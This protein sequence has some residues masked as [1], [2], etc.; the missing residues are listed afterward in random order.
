MDVCRGLGVILIVIVHAGSIYSAIGHEAV[1]GWIRMLDLAFAPYRVPLLMVLS[2]MLLSR[3]LAKGVSTYVKGKLRNLAWP[4]VIWTAIY[5]LAVSGPQGWLAIKPWLGNTPFWYLAYLGVFFSIG[6]VCARVPFGLIAVYALAIAMIAPS[7]PIYG[8][9]LFVMMSYFFAGAHIGLYLERTPGIIRS[10]WMVALLPLAVGLSVHLMTSEAAAKYSPFI[11]PLVLSAILCLCSV[12]STVARGPISTAFAFA[13]R[14]SLVFYVVH[15][16]VYILVYEF[17]FLQGITS[18]YLCIGL[19][20]ALGILAPTALALSKPRSTMV[21]RLFEAP[22]FRFSPALERVMARVEVMLMPSWA[23]QQA[24]SR[25]L[26]DEDS[27]AAE[28]T[29]R[30]LAS[31]YHFPD[32]NRPVRARRRDSRTDAQ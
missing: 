32:S 23:Q 15:L 27:R 4:F 28:T 24:I 17:L 14:N 8:R 6:L 1:P 16:P 18:A 19:A 22:D 31:R 21:R 13:G 20:L 9:Q 30:E 10:R 7:E 25:G 2:G 11:V 12:F 5:L 3:S 26:E 29:H